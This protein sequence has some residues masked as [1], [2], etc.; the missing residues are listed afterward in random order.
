MTSGPDNSPG[1]SATGAG[2][3]IDTSALNQQIVQ[4]VG[5][6]N[7]QTAAGLPQ[8][9]QAIP[10]TMVT[11]VV[12][13]AVQNASNYMAAVMQLSLAVQAVVAKNIAENPANA[14]VEAPVLA[15]AQSM[16]TE[17]VTAFSA[18][19]TAVNTAG[20]LILGDMKLG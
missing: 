7:A 3:G 11:Q 8:V 4:A 12:G 9:V 14:P 5:F 16:V 6:T 19:S 17:A 15:T 1:A 10:D 13:L 2:T 18:V 20:T